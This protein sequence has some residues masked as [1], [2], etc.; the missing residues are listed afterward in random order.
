MPNSCARALCD[1]PPA[2][3]LARMANTSLLE[4]LAIPCC[5][6]SK[7]T[8]LPLSSRSLLFSACVPKNKC[9][10]LT[11][12]G[13]SQLCNTCMPFGIFPNEIYQDA[14]CATPACPKRPYPL[15]RRCVLPV[16]IQQPASGI[17]STKTA[18]RESLISMSVA[19]YLRTT[20]QLPWVL[21][22]HL[23][24]VIRVEIVLLY[25]RK[26]FIALY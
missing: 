15:S 19:C 16:H 21:P 3:Y 9:A 11:Q 4:S 12:Q 26:K 23:Q 5:T 1:D 10:G 2:A 7:A 13:R 25:L 17:G 20:A 24:L 14:R 22:S 8:C 18:K 6:P